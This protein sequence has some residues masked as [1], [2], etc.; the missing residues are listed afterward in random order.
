MILEGPDFWAHSNLITENLIIFTLPYHPD[1]LQVVKKVHR[2][3]YQKK[4]GGQRKNG[5]LCPARRCKREIAVGT[6]DMVFNFYSNVD[7]GL[8]EHSMHLTD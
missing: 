6:V 3:S 8:T 2:A 4:N 7:A 1:T 5:G